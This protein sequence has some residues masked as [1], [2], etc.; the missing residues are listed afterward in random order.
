MSYLHRF[1]VGAY[2]TETWINWARHFWRDG[3]AWAYNFSNTESRIYLW[4]GS[5]SFFLKKRSWLPCL[6]L[7]VLLKPQ[8]VLNELIVFTVLSKSLVTVSFTM[9]T[10]LILSLALIPKSRLWWLLALTKRFASLVFQDYTQ[11]V[12]PAGS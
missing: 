2:Q 7:S 8:N 10:T 4:K 9:F 6:S 1:A 11:N 3:K 5:L 12:S